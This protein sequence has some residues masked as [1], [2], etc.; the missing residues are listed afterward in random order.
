MNKEKIEYD[1]RRQRAL[2]LNYVDRI[3]TFLYNQLYNHPNH[4]VYSGTIYYGRSFTGDILHGEEL[5]KRWDL[6]EVRKTH[7]FICKLIRNH[8]GSNVSIWLFNE[9]HKDIEQEDG[10]TKKGAYHTNF[11]IGGID[12]E[13]IEQPNPYLIKLFYQPDELGIP[14]NCRN[15]QDIE[16]L[17]ILL[18]NVCIRDAKWVGRHPSALNLQYAPKKSDTETFYFLKDFT[19]LDQLLEVV[20]FDNSDFDYSEITELLQ[21]KTK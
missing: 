6:L 5:R 1:L 2:E 17:K 21:R 16:S 11:Y 9:R 3:K 19:T 14:V 12:D 7:E 8:F 13:V 20:D 4:P 15:I 18:L 10:S